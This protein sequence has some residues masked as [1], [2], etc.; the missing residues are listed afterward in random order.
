MDWTFSTTGAALDVI[1][2]VEV[3]LGAADE[4]D[5]VDEEGGKMVESLP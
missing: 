4:V 2:V 5:E 3:E 1:E